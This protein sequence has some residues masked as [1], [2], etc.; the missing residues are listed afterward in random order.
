MGLFAPPKCPRCEAPLVLI[1]RW[2]G[3]RATVPISCAQCGASL[4]YDSGGGVYVR[5]DSKS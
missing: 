2:F 5:P 1:K 4:L 3:L